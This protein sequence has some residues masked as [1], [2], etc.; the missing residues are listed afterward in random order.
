[1]SRFTDLLS[2]CCGYV[3][4]RRDLGSRSFVRGGH[5]LFSREG[6]SSFGTSTSCVGRRVMVAGPVTVIPDMRCSKKESAF[7][8][9][10]HVRRIIPALVCVCDSDKCTTIF[11]SMMMLLSESLLR[12]NIWTMCHPHGTTHRMKKER[13]G[14]GIISNVPQTD[15]PS[16]ISTNLKPLSMFSKENTPLVLSRGV[17]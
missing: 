3:F 1:M 15:I 10:G 8:K 4:L 5:S 17:V 13:E 16:S 7:E 14:H 2:C 12:R 11:V 9:A 6:R